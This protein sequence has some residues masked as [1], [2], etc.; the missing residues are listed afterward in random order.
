MRYFPLVI[1]MGTLIFGTVAARASEVNVQRRTPEATVKAYDRVEFIVDP[2]TTYSNPYDPD[3]IAIDAT[4][5]GPKGESLVLPAFWDQTFILRFAPT[6][7]GKWSMTA[8]VRDKS[9][10]RKSAPLTFDVAESASRGFI[11]RAKDNPRYFQYDS[12]D[13]YFVIGI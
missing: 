9:G 2:G 1:V 3:E 8:T 11:R 4:F 10:E 5:T 6:S 7:P 12:G 13:P